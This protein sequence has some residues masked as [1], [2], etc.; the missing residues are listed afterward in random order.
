[1]HQYF[2]GALEDSE[3]SEYDQE[4]PLL[5]TNCRQTRGTGKKSQTAITRYW[6]DEQSQATSSPFPIKMIAKL[7]CTTKHRTVTE[8]HN[9]SNNQQPTNNNRPTALE[10]T[11]A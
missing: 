11:E 3:N 7:K 5:I 2:P 9:G 1:M 10:R 6:E 4:I 8:S